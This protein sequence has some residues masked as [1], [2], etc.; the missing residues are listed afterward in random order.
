LFGSHADDRQEVEGAI[1]VVP[2]VIDSIPKGAAELLQEALDGYSE[3][4]GDMDDVN[5][6]EKNPVRTSKPPVGPRS[7]AKARKR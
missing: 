4:S 3:F 7:S 6:W 5:T 1:Y 2:S